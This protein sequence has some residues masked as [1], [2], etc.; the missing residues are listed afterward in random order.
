MEL[1]IGFYATGIIVLSFTLWRIRKYLTYCKFIEE[2][3]DAYVYGSFDDSNTTNYTDCV[4][5]SWIMN[6][7]VLK[8]HGKLG[9][10][11]QDHMF[12]NT[13]ATMIWFSLTLGIGI[14]ILGVV[15]VRSIQMAG[16][17]LII[18]L[19]GAFAILGSGDAKDSEDL[20]AMLQTQKIED[21]QLHDYSY[22][23]FALGSIKK[24]DILS[25]IIGMILVISAP[26]GEVILTL[27]SW[28]IATLTVYF[29]L[30]PTLF[31]SEF[32]IPM[33]ILYLTAAWPILVF[34]IVS[35]A[36]KAKGSRGETHYNLF[37]PN[38]TSLEEHA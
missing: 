11:F 4:S 18:F 5:H 31:L 14:L 1:I 29:I 37:K 9:Q 25:A 35:V 28:T 38:S 17:L 34:I 7:V 16:M 36:Q 12:D 24:R 30:N 26:Y 22:A 23:I 33:A 10:R 6:N 3:G 8:K 19:I 2:L 32:S 20:L 27:A 13:Y 21:L 15:L